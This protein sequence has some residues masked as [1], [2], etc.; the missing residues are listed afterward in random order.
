MIRLGFNRV[1]IYPK[2]G[3]MIENRGT[4]VFHGRCDIGNN[5]YI[6]IGKYSTV[7]FGD[8]FSATASFRLAS[9]VGITFNKDV[10][11]GW[12]CMFIDSD[13]HRLTRDDGKPV[14]PL[15]TI[16]IGRNVWFG[17]NCIIMKR[18]KIPNFTTI[19]AGTIVSKVVNVPEKTVVG[20]PRT[21]EV[22]RTGIWRDFTDDQIV[23]DI[24]EGKDRL[25]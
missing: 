18:T 9:Y 2:T 3:I 14:K 15:G 13:F 8:K 16:H 21:V 17:N 22:L 11:V 4:M 24:T 25:T 6:S 10:S 12:N 5:S 1:S 19:A 20:N 23:Y 7:E